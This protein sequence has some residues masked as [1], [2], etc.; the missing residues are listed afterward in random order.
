MTVR[1]LLNLTLAIFRLAELGFFGLTIETF[2]Q[3]PFNCGAEESEHN[4]NKEDLSTEKIERNI[5]WTK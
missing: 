2:K 1:L 5:I 3:T 4:V